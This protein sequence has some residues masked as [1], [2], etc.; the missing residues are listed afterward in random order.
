MLSGTLQ[1]RTLVDEMMRRSTGSRTVA[2]ERVVEQA[3]YHR[4]FVEDL[5]QCAGGE[6]DVELFDLESTGEVFRHAHKQIRTQHRLPLLIR[7]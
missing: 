6:F 4:A 3:E 7:K 5:K 2:E 1:S